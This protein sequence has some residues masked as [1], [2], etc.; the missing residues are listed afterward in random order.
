M[1]RIIL[2]I[3]SLAILFAVLNAMFWAVV[4]LGHFVVDCSVKA[5]KLVKG[6]LL[7]NIK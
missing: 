2:G 5:Y 7:H 3:I 1:I 4:M 6:K